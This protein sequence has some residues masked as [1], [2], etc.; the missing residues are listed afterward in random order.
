MGMNPD[1]IVS[2]HPSITLAQVYAALAY[3]FDHKADI[4]ADIAEGEHF[5]AELKAKTPP[6]KLQKILEAR[7]AENGSDDSLPPGL[8]L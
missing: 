1:E 2:A 8:V 5:V 4:D 6:S 3:Y 7:L